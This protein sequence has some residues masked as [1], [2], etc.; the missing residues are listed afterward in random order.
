M[1]VSES[2]T[3]AIQSREALP[4]HAHVHFWIKVL[5]FY[6]FA[7][8]I[9]SLISNLSD[10]AINV[11]ATHWRSPLFGHAIQLALALLFIFRAKWAAQTVEGAS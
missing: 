4:P 5:G 10:V 3:S 1:L 8:A 9:G 6:F 7:S 2:G 11:H